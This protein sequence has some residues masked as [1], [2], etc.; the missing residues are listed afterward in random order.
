MNE[1]STPVSETGSGAKQGSRRWMAWLLLI[2][3]AIVWF[4]GLGYRDLNQPDEGRYAEIPRE[5]VATGNWVTP[6]LDGLKYFEKPP[7]QYWMTAVSFELF[8]QSNATSRLWT[9]LMGFLTVPWVFFLGLRLYDRRTAFYGASLVAS[10]LIWVAMGHLNTLDMGVSALLAFGVGALALAQTERGRRPR[11]VMGWML[12]GWAML[13][14]ATL[15]KGLIGLVLPGGAVV[16]YSL[17]QRDWG[18]WRHLHLVKGLVVLVALT[19]PWFVLVSRANPTFLWFFFIHEHFLRYLTPEAHRSQPWWF[20]LGILW[21]GMLPWLGAG[22]RSVVRAGRS[23]ALGDGSF[24]AERFFWTY[25]AFMMVFFSISDSKLVPYI[26][27]LYPFLALLAGNQLARRLR[28]G[29]DAV[30]GAALAIAL[31]GVAVF[32][33]HFST[34][35]IPAHLLLAGRPWVVAS[36]LVLLAGAGGAYRLRHHGR[37]AV[38]SLAAASLISFQLLN[39]GYQVLSPMFSSREVAR[40]MAPIADRGVPLYSVGEYEQALPFYLK[41]TMTLVRYQGELSYGIQREPHKW[42]PTVSA[43]VKIWD[44]EKQALAVMKPRLYSKLKAAGV[45]MRVLYKDPRRVAVARR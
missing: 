32:V 36:A 18:L 25:G 30:A 38:L 29:V 16:F 45:P 12:L 13:A 1:W 5:M 41:R 17:W 6:R 34:P 22:A 31:L 19:A 11:W 44:S 28:I 33:R 24:D 15:S 7:L 9:A 8:G 42:I 43:F 2:A 14:A 27:P 21:L 4:G 37:Y 39:L 20:F 10:M 26:L 3:F 35:W 40:A 23:W